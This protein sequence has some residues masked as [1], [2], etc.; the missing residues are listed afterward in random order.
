MHC[1]SGLSIP[2]L[3]SNLNFAGEDV[4]T[5]GL[6]I[7]ASLDF[8]SQM[9]YGRESTPLLCSADDGDAARL[10]SDI[11][12]YNLLMQLPSAELKPFYLFDCQHVRDCLNK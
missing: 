10:A 7:S 1:K 2:G 11:R 5:E 6:R 3:F 12:G 9:S 4:A 8:E